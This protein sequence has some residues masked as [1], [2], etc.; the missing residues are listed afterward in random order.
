MRHHARNLALWGTV[1]GSAVGL[2]VDRENTTD[3]EISA[4][5][6]IV[7]AGIGAG[8]GAAIGALFNVAGASGN[9]L[10]EK[11]GIPTAVSIAPIVSP[12]RQ[13]IALALRW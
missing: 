4:A 8:V 11:A 13:G 9:V 3:T 5:G 1:A 2:L 6:T 10:Y 7:C 12:G